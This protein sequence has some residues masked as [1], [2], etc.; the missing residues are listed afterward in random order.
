MNR[1]K[2]QL[3]QVV[4]TINGKGIISKRF[5]T[6]ADGYLYEVLINGDYLL[7]LEKELQSEKESKKTLEE[8]SKEELLELLK[9]YSDYVDIN[10]KMFKV[11]IMNVSDYINS[12]KYKDLYNQKDEIREISNVSIDDTSN[13]H[14]FAWDL[15]TE[16]TDD[17]LK[18]V[19]EY[20]RETSKLDNRLIFLP[21]TTTDTKKET[22]FS[23][24]STNYINELQEQAQK[25][26]TDFFIPS[27]KYMRENAHK[28][29]KI[30]INN[31]KRGDS[32]LVLSKNI[33][34][35]VIDVNY[36]IN[37]ALVLSNNILYNVDINDIRKAIK[38][39]K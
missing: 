2:Y 18:K 22:T 6:S 17:L 10:S 25:I 7:Y 31:L 24:N 15:D 23:L 32:V 19:E 28:L 37:K 13:R 1:S 4:K 38:V 36:K 9:T 34:A 8:M 35:N 5:E 20:L 11:S 12:N 30:G 39:E 3:G 16:A 33:I 27:N 26:H 29:S 21:S 14:L